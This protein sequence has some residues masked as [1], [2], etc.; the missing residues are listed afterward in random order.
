MNPFGDNSNGTGIGGSPFGIDVRLPMVGIMRTMWSNFA[1]QPD[2]EL[3]KRNIYPG[4]GTGV[5]QFLGG[6][7]GDGWSNAASL[8]PEDM[9]NPR[10]EYLNRLTD[11]SWNNLLQ[12]YD[13]G[14]E[15]ASA[16]IDNLTQGMEAQCHL[17]Q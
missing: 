15:N 7:L 8:T 1:S 16:A 14:S 9:P 4:N 2:L 5:A 6:V 11:S 17:Y 3:F 12:R 10:L 13:G